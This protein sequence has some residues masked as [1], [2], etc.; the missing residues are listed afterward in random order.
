M[1]EEA[2]YNASNWEYSSKYLY[3]KFN[4]VLDDPNLLNRGITGFTFSPERESRKM[5]MMDINSGN[6]EFDTEKIIA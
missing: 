1:R 5:K 2:K 6:I 4:G 3:D